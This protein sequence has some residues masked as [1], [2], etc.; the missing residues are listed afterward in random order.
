MGADPE[1]LTM[2]EAAERAAISGRLAVVFGL[3]AIEAAG[4]IGICVTKFREMVAD[5][6]MPRPRR[7]DRRLVWDV[8]ELR[9]AFKSLPYDG[10]GPDAYGEPDPVETSGADD[11]WDDLL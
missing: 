8:D 3:P 2:G 11:G 4:S 5:G 10:D 7:V 1:G 6:R 9:D